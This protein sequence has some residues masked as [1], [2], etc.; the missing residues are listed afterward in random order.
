MLLDKVSF[1]KY[2]GKTL[3]ISYLLTSIY[4]D[5]PE[6]LDYIWKIGAVIFIFSFNV[7]RPKPIVL[8]KYS[9]ILLAVSLLVSIGIFLYAILGF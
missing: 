6:I 2:G 7:L 1:F 9:K 5:I 8:A 4:F 3:L